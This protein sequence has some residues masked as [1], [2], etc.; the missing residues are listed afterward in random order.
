MVTF[1][2]MWC[3]ACDDAKTIY[4]AETEEQYCL[5]CSHKLYRIG[6]INNEE[7]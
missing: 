4:E 6:W 2:I 1:S 7:V 5:D 3:D